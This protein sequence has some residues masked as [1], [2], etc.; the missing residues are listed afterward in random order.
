VARRGEA[1]YQ[2]LSRAQIA[3]IT[4]PADYGIDAIAE[5]HDHG[6]ISLIRTA[7]ERVAREE[8]TN[9][10]LPK[11]F[12]LRSPRSRRSTLSVWGLLGE[13]SFDVGS[14][15]F[16]DT[17]E[18]AY[19]SAQTAISAA[20]LVSAGE[21]D[22]AYALARPPGHHAGPAYFGG[23]CYLNNAA[24]A[25]NW[26]VHQ[27]ERV[28]ILDIDYHH[29]NGTQDIFYHRSDVFVCSLHADPLEEYPY[30]WGYAD[31]Y[32]AG[33]GENYNFNYPLPRG[34]GPEA[35]LEAFERA[36][37]RLSRFVPTVLLISL[38]QDILRGDPVGD[39]EL[40]IETV[41][42]LGSKIKALDV[43]T[44]VIQEGGYNLD[45]LGESVV[46]FLQAFR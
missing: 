3:P 6:M 34:T 42:T 5:V 16:G 35:Y 1:I 40:D 11:T 44:V 12:N 29:G 8:N 31:E 22:A 15:I 2:A 17:W 14:P 36:I 33:P 7:H 23:F 46:A 32:G 13:Y 27:G 24:I 37:E 39:F 26:L 38:G 21:I 9:V 18:A 4:P 41:A 28:A 43:A 30:F 45:L 25:A 19:W 20:A 10:A